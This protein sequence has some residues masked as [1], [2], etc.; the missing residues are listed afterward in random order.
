VSSLREYGSAINVWW[1]RPIVAPS[2]NAR[3]CVTLARD[4]D[5]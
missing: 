2:E 4:E 3:L 5:Q 1:E